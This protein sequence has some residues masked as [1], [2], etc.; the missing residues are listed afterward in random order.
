MS[1]IKVNRIENTST[2]DGGVS[3]DTDGHV[4]IDGQQLPTA[5]P[6]SNRNLII[7][8]AMQVSQRSTSNTGQTASAYR[9]CDRFEVKISNLGTWTIEQSTDAPSG[10]S[11]S[12]KIDC[13]TADSSP[14]AADYLF[15]RYI[16]EAQDLQLLGYG[17]ADAK[18]L[19]MSFWVKSN[20]TGD[21]S[22]LLNSPDGSDRAFTT[23]YN[24]AAADT[25]EYKTV[26]IPADT[27]GTINNDNGSGFEIEWWLNSGST[28]SGSTPASGWSARVNG[29]RNNSNL[30]VGGAVNDYLQITG[31]QLEVG[32]KATPFEHRSY[33]Q[34]LAL[35]QRYY[36][37]IRRN[38]GVLGMRVGVGQA[39]NSNQV[40]IVIP[41]PTTMREAPTALEQSGTA[42]DYGLIS[43]TGSGGDCT[44]VPTFR[45]ATIDAIMVRFTDTGHVVAGHASQGYLDQPE[46]FLAWSAEL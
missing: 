9:A 42:S 44:S 8:G 43:A 32:S 35:C 5:G 25:W 16:V 22:L 20:K 30:G 36:Q 41:Y 39:I 19:V 23:T 10:F 15:I 37:I 28:F 14:A 18:P 29:A 45:F 17:T 13:T 27:G 1:T 6:L 26:S 33:G 4:T 7:N 21:A 2:T 3:I 34:E 46:A 38:P 11:N 40:E 24:I 31:V 12:L